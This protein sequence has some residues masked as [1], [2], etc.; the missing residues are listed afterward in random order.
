MM[1]TAPGLC[2]ISLLSLRVYCCMILKVNYINILT[3]N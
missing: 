2:F 3:A 1:S